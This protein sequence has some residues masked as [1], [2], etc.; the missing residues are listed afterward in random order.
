MVEVHGNDI[1]VDG[2]YLLN[3]SDRGATHEGPIAEYKIKLIVSSGYPRVEPKL[4]EVGGKIPKEPDRHVNPGDGSC[5]VTVW[6]HWLACHEDNSFSAFMDGP[7]HE[8]FLVQ[9][10]FDQTGEWRFGERA[11]FLEGMEEAYADALSGNVPIVD[12]RHCL[13][14]LSQECLKGHWSCPCG[15]GRKLRDC[16]RK[17][18]LELKERIEPWL[19]KQMRDR[20]GPGS[21]NTRRV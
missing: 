14:L 1:H 11:H 2:I 21:L 13:S 3:D 20:L 15:S 10:L 6:E 17:E 4:F 18:L 16:H 5:C 12:I 7:I 8:Y 9:Y 19:A